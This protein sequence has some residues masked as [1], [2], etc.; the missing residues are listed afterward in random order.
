MMARIAM[1]QALQH[2]R[3]EA[4]LEPTRKAA[5]KYRIVRS[6]RRDDCGGDLV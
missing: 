5:K 1:L 4:A 2:G 3:P 6:R